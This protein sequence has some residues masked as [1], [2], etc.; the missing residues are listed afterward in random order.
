MLC[1]YS[2]TLETVHAFS[3]TQF[4]LQETSSESLYFE[5]LS[6]A[7]CCIIRN[8]LHSSPTPSPSDSALRCDASM[9]PRRTG[10]VTHQPA[11]ERWQAHQDSFVR[12]WCGW[13]SSNRKSGAENL[14]AL[15]HSGG[16]HLHHGGSMRRRW[17]SHTYEFTAQGNRTRL[18]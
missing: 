13:N 16:N 14:K 8:W 11:T 9:I 1:C 6:K 10:R 3:F 4:K 12:L 17:I 7:I 18:G 15:L 5:S 2:A